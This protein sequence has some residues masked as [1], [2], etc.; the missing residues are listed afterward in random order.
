MEK[1]VI[2]NN[3]LTTI[4]SIAASAYIFLLGVPTLIFQTYLAE[5]LREIYSKRETTKRNFLALRKLGV[6]LIGIIVVVLLGNVLIPI[7]YADI[8]KEGWPDKLINYKW[9]HKVFLSYYAIVCLALFVFSFF[10]YQYILNQLKVGN[11]SKQITHA[12]ISEAKAYYIKHGTINRDDIQDLQILGKSFI[13]SMKKKELLQELITFTQFILKSE[14]HT[15]TYDGDKLKSLIEEVLID[16]FCN[17]NDASSRSNLNLVLDICKLI[18]NEPDNDYLYIDR[19][20]VALLADKIAHIALDKNYPYAY[21]QSF[22]LLK[23]LPN[24]SEMLFEICKKNYKNQRYDL[25]QQKIIALTKAFKHTEKE[26][27]SESKIRHILCYLSWFLAGN[28]H[29][30]FFAVQ[31]IKD[32]I[33]I[34]IITDKVVTDSII[35]FQNKADYDSARDINAL[36][37]TFFG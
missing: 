6:F 7:I 1:I 14:K 23:K 12:V 20:A 21:E 31:K 5:E 32:L 2:D 24:T 37:K 25:I 35:H 17:T 13:A 22:E 9:G 16:A 27:L 26:F 34:N 28:E 19:H 4:L 36:H 8:L 30:N 15:H 33:S 29:M 11:V 3:W 10:I 18:T